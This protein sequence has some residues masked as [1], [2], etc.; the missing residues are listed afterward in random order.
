[1][2]F[3]SMMSNIYMYVGCLYVKCVFSWNGYVNNIKHLL[4]L[5]IKHCTLQGPV[6]SM[7]EFVQKGFGK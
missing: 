4:K 6:V 7:S 1:M 2:W 5:N 3:F